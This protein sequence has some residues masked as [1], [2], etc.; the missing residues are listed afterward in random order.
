MCHVLL[1]T[2]ATSDSDAEQRRGCSEIVLSPLEFMIKSYET[3][4]FLMIQHIQPP[5]RSLNHRLIGIIPDW[6][7]MKSKRLW[8]SSARW[9]VRLAN[10]GKIMGK[11]SENHGKLRGNPRFFETYNLAHCFLRVKNVSREDISM[12]FHDTWFTIQ[13]PGD[14]CVRLFG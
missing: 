8:R 11:P 6:I 5:I 9:A 4:M 14:L 1:Y 3:F 2:S 12:I 7:L 13:Y 10:H